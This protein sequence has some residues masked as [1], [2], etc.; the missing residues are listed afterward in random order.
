[1]TDGKLLSIHACLYL[2]ILLYNLLYILVYIN[3]SYFI[4][5]SEKVFTR[6][7]FFL[8]MH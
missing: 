3:I 5:T 1:M 4:N 6:D 2:Y 8:H 7:D